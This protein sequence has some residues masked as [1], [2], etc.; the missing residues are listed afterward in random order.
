MK[1]IILS[2]LS[3][4]PTFTI[5]NECSHSAN[6][7]GVNYVVS[8]KNALSGEVIS[9]EALNFWRLND[10]VAYEYA[11]RQVTEIWNLVSNGQMRPV[12]YFDEYQ[13]G[14]E[15]QPMEMNSDR[16][17][18]AKN[19]IVS[20]SFRDKLVKGRAFGFGCD[21]VVRYKQDKV[22]QTETESKKAKY[23]AA[24]EWLSSYQLPKKIKTSA[25]NIVVTW[26]AKKIITD[27]TLIKK[28]FTL[29]EKYQTIDYADVGDS[30]SDPMV[31]KMLNHKFM[32][33]HSSHAGHHH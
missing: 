7:V 12:R 32:K 16:D 14:I 13:H 10:Q 20:N 21:K 29:R 1:K 33:A 17:W 11:E 25:N 31:S 6:I 19:N 2:I 3:L 24:L 9:Q 26:E 28:A 27:S 18:S 8:K 22:K 23:Q 15:Y 30:E 5:A 4:W